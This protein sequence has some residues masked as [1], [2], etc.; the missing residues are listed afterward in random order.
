MLKIADWL[1]TNYLSIADWVIAVV[2]VIAPVVLSRQKNDKIAH[3]KNS[4]KEY[5]AFMIKISFYYFALICIFY[6]VGNF[7]HILDYSGRINKKIYLDLCIIL[8]SIPS[9]IASVIWNSRTKIIIKCHRNITR[10]IITYVMTAGPIAVQLILNRIALQNQIS[11]HDWALLGAFLN[12]AFVIVALFIIDGHDFFDY[13]EI[14]LDL[15]DS[16][17]VHAVVPDTI[18]CQ[19]S[20]IV[21]DVNANNQVKYPAENIKKLHYLR[22]NKYRSG[23]AI[24]IT[25]IILSCFFSFWYFLVIGLVSQFLF[26]SVIVPISVTENQIVMEKGDYYQIEAVSLDSDAGQLRYTISEDNAIDV[27][28]SGVISVSSDLP[29]GKYVTAE[30]IIMDEIGNSATVQVEV[31]T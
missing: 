27:S 13:S 2:A 26:R 1:K 5:I 4:L 10:K 28:P 23:T 29:E 6:W 30:I 8:S 31:R 21:V 12:V 17:K 18:Y 14:L 15:K 20:Y 19:G 24:S 9:I 3:K 11:F 7:L 22:R 25:N 16:E